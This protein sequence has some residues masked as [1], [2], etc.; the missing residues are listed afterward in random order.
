MKKFETRNW[1]FLVENQ[2]LLRIV[3][4]QPISKISKH[5][6]PLRHALPL[7]RTKERLSKFDSFWNYR[8]HHLH[9]DRRAS[10]NNGNFTITTPLSHHPNA[11]LARRHHTRFNADQDSDVWKKHYVVNGFFLHVI[12]NKQKR[13]QFLAQWLGRKSRN[14]E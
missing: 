2:N 6:R 7:L 1:S 9:S 8:P 14:L 13:I 11:V 3:I 12:Y 4:S 5:L 10:G